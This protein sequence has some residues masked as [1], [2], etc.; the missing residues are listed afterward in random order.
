LEANDPKYFVDGFLIK[1]FGIFP[2]GV[3]KD[4]L[5]EE[6]R[7]FLVYL[8]G[9]TPSQDDWTIQVDYKT[10]LQNIKD[11]KKIDISKTDFDL[12]KMQGKNITELQKERLRQEKESLIHELNNKFGIKD[13]V[14]EIKIKGLPENVDIDPNKNHNKK[15]WDL[16]Q[17][18]PDGIKES[19]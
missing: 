4:N 6:Q 18:N 19:S 16:L 2:L 1:H 10:K 14:E 15:L 13:E 12:A 11:I 9:L 7:I 8:V 3:E 17:G 5:F